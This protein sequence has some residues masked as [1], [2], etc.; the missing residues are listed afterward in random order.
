MSAHAEAFQPLHGAPGLDDPSL[1]LP[2]TVRAMAGEAGYD[3]DLD[4]LNAAL[5]LSWMVCAVPG[6]A[7]IDSWMMYARD[8]FLIPAG[9]LFGM[10]IREIHPPEAARGLDAAAEFDQ[11]FDA[12]YRPLILRALEHDQPVLAWQGWPSERRLWWG[13]IQAACVEGVGFRGVTISDGA[14]GERTETHILQKPPIQ[15]YVVETIRPAQPDAD[16]LLE[17]ALDHA[18][19]VLGNEVGDR[20]GVVTGPAAYGEWIA[21]IGSPVRPASVSEARLEVQSSKH[22]KAT[23]RGGTETGDVLRTSNFELRPSAPRPVACAPGS[24]Q[25]PAAENTPRTQVHLRLAASV[26]ACHQ[27]GIRFLERQLE[28]TSGGHRTRMER[29]LQCS[30]DIRHALDEL[31]GAGDPSAT[32]LRARAATERLLAELHVSTDQT[33]QQPGH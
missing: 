15:L 4:D 3:V 30:E 6:E 20:F 25:T 33:P 5:G 1:S 18:R 10:E 16:E 29:L 31:V 2:R 24:D 14:R 9:R 26:M 22:E 11:H 21:R 7:D 12:S 13:I 17:L 19:R 28:R 27:S 23:P 8:A 32:L